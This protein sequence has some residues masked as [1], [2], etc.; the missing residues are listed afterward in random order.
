MAFNGRFL[1]N[2]IQFASS[3]EVNYQK[4]IALSGRSVEELS[5]EACVVENHVYNHL[6]EQA[7]ELTN[8]PFFGLH[9]GEALNL[10]ASGLINQIV[11]TSSTV[12]QALELCCDY[13]NL[14]CSALPMQLIEQ[15]ENYKLCFTPDEL[16]LQQSAVAVQQTIEGT[17]AFSIREFHSLTRM[18]HNPISIDLPWEEPKDISE[19]E[20]VFSCPVFFNKEQVTIYLEKEHVNDKVTTSDFD[21]LRI[22]IQHAEEKSAKINEEKGF[23]SLVKQSMINLIKSEFPT[24]EQVSSHLNISLRTLQRRLK[25]EGVTYKQLI[26]DLRKDFAL[27]Y[28]K[29]S[30]L[31]YA[32]IAYLL[33]YA[34]VSAFSR[35][36][37]KWTGQSPKTFREHHISN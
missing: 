36:F 26:N 31:N 1:L 11:H 20:R 29:R 10:A 35:A 22:L 15:K 3:K 23:A 8:D 2:L 18:K 16:W 14:G 30:D 34:D 9:A 32:D 24:I 33:S 4:L 13:A 12:K 19:Y 7:V 5:S 37:K 21:L 17:L 6:L 25:S 27:S 28:L